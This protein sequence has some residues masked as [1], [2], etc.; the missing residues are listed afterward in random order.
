MLVHYVVIFVPILN[1]IPVDMM[2]FVIVAP[3]LLNSVLCAVRKSSAKLLKLE[4]NWKMKVLSQACLMIDDKN[5]S[6]ASFSFYFCQRENATYV[7]VSLIN[8][9]LFYDIIIMLTHSRFRTN[10]YQVSQFVFLQCTQFMF[11][12]PLAAKTSLKSTLVKM[13]M[14]L[15]GL[16]L[17]MVYWILLQWICNLRLSIKILS[18]AF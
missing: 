17:S 2:V 13:I 4:T 8:Q 1:C 3:V 18:P 16:V 7:F 11:W 15:F 10:L 6:S 12:E 14:L 9:I 5:T